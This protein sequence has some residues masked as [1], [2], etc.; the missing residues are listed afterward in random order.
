[1]KITLTKYTFRNGDVSID[2]SH[3]HSPYLPVEE[4]FEQEIEVDEA[5][6]RKIHGSK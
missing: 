3:S 1:M 2:S 6:W 4:E 5:K